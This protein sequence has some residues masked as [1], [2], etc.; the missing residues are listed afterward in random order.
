MLRDMDTTPPT[1]DRTKPVRYPGAADTQRRLAI[2]A[3][4]IA[5]A[6]ADLAAGRVID[7]ADVDAWIDSI[8]SDHE[9][10]VPYSGR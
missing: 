6:D 1:D 5:E 9:R 4:M 2:E 3:E 8:G 10:P 7:A